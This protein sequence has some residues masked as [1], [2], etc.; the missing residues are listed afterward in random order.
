MQVVRADRDEVIPAHSTRRLIDAL[1]RASTSEVTLAGAGH[2][3][4]D[5]D[6]AYGAALQAFIRRDATGR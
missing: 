5:A 2:N 3:T 6:P 4:V 1:P